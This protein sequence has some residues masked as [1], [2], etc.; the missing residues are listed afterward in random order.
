MNPEQI[1]DVIS[2]ND[3]TSTG[4]LIALAL[5]FGW[6]IIYLFKVNQELHKKFIDELKASNEAL[7]KVNN[8]QN[9]FVNNMIKLEKK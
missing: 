7:I 6:V 2:W 5:A 3:A 8:F 4:I 1:H 9:E